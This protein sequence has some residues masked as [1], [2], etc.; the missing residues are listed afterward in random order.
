M[1]VKHFIGLDDYNRDSLDGLLARAAELKADL[2]KG[3]THNGLAGKSVALI[4]E[5]PSTRTR[6]SFE[7]GV[8]QLGGYPLFLSGKETQ[9]KRGEPIADTARVLSRYVDMI[10][11]R[12]HGHEDVIEL[13][14]KSSVPVING[15]TDLL[16]PCQILADLLTMREVGLDLDDCSVCYVGDGNNVANSW[17][18]A[19]GVFNF[20]LRIACP[21]GYDPN[22]GLMRKAREAGGRVNVF[23]DSLEAASG[24]D[25]LYT[26]VWVSMGQEDEVARRKAAFKGF[27]IGMDLID[28][29]APEV[30]VMHC[31][32]A[33]R[34]EEITDEAIES[35][36]SIV[37]DQAE[38]RLHAQK[39][40][41][42]F[43]AKG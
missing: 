37:F 2:K 17:I 22:A 10:M 35:G 7:V 12:T 6:V 23:R 15:L 33:H 39:S 9:L 8:H 19:A 20:D 28:A 3:K 18:N 40:I 36:H 26:D 30:K 13:A 1:A 16:H 31:L 29:A 5:K 11:I 42:E 21:E 38:N 41:M 24:A 34:G 25:V 27:Q 14:E 32:P 4:F 43:L